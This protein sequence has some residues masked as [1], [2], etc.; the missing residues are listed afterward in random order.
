MKKISTIVLAVSVFM[1]SMMNVGA[2]SGL[3]QKTN[4]NY[5]WVKSK[6]AI[7][8]VDVSQVSKT[9]LDVLA[10]SGANIG[11]D[12]VI[13][14][15]S[16]NDSGDTAI[17]VTNIESEE[18]EK[19]IYVSYVE[20]ENNNM[21]IDNSMAKVLAQGPDFDMS[22]SYPPTS[23]GGDYMVHA[24]ATAALYTNDGWFY[25]YKPYKCSFYYENY[26]GVSVDSIEVQYIADGFLYSYPGFENLYLN[27]YVHGVS[28]YK[29][30]P[31]VGA[32]YSNVNYFE[33]DK[34]LM[35]DFGSPSV[36][37]FLTFVCTV[38]GQSRQYTIDL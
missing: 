8:A 7:M 29:A 11:D 21:V 2:V 34:V 1:T 12:T 15:L 31:V 18:V 30:N 26:A 20:D 33:T 6:S 17:C 37:H 24:T 9:A 13:E 25:Y 14:V 4:I 19:D 3:K 16:V 38:N 35:T 5:D 22:A 28:V 32:V 23:W 10:S 27:E 36:G